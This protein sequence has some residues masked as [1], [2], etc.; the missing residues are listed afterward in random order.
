MAGYRIDIEE[1]PKWIKG[2]RETT[3]NLL[4]QKENLDSVFL[5]KYI[6]KLMLQLKI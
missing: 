6:K 5:Q 2:M 1:I 3:D 4:T